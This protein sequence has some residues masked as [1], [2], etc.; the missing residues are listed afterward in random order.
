MY[1]APSLLGNKRRKWLAWAVTVN[2]RGRKNLEPG[3]ENLGGYSCVDRRMK[4]MSGWD[5]IQLNVWSQEE[6]RAFKREKGVAVFECGCGVWV[7]NG[8]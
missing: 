6:N 4:G 5:K 1:L 7:G 3:L 8:F 2:H